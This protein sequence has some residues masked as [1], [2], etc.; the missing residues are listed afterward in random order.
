MKNKSYSIPRLIMIIGHHLKGRMDK[1]LSQHNLTISQFRVLSYLWKHRSKKINQKMIH[2]F[3]EIK[4]SSLTKLIRILTQKGLIKKI[5]DSEDSRNKIILL[6]EKGKKIKN[7]CMQNI[8][9]S[10]IYLLKDFSSQEI[11]ALTNLLLK[12]KNRIKSQT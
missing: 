9:A 12:I 8:I 7:I 4:P 2:N 1:S 5:A 11:D 6:T 3:L 10:E